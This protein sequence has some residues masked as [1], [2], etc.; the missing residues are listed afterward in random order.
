MSKNAVDKAL[1]FRKGY[2]FFQASSFL[3]TQKLF[4]T[5]NFYL[6]TVKNSENLFSDGTP[7]SSAINLN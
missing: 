2:L 6:V 3:E 4:R 7:P 5:G 1:W